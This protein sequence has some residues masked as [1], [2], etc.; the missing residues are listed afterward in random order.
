MPSGAEI[1]DEYVPWM[2]DRCRQCSGKLIVAELDGEVAGFATILTKV[3]SDEIDDGPV[4]FGLVG[5]LVVR[6]EY[7]GRGIGTALLEAA[8]SH[9]R[10]HEVRW[11][12]IGVLADNEVADRMYEA[13]G[14]GTRFLMREKDLRNS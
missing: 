11:L 1:V 6:A 3:Q 2:L 12:R 4:E 10:A 8:E 13:M 5:D 7:R 14:F 9:S